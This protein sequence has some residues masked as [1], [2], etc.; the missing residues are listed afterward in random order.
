MKGQDVRNNPQDDSKS[1]VKFSIESKPS[2]EVEK[3]QKVNSVQNWRLYSSSKAKCS[4]RWKFPKVSEFF[5]TVDWYFSLLFFQL[6]LSIS[7]W[8]SFQGV[9]LVFTTNREAFQH[10]K[11][12]DR[13]GKNDHVRNNP[14]KDLYESGKLRMGQIMYILRK[15]FLLKP[16]KINKAQ[17]PS[18]DRESFRIWN[19]VFVDFKPPNNLKNYLAHQRKSW[20]GNQKLNEGFG[21][22][23]RKLDLPENWLR[24]LTFWIF[25]LHNRNKR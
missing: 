4:D 10:S 22:W 12:W 14:L 3:A 18:Y 20:K 21:S 19:E 1:S 11:N 13:R 15:L 24:I 5:I 7:D 23:K 16:T 25:R 2:W 8:N 17:V 9:Q 6:F